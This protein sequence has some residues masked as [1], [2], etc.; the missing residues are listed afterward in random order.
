MPFSHTG[1]VPSDP[2]GLDPRES[3]LADLV[4]Q[5][6]T[7]I[8]SAIGTVSGPRAADAAE[9][10]IHQSLWQV[11]RGE[12][13]I[14]HPSSYVYKAAVR[15]TVRAVRRMG[16]S[17]ADSGPDPSDG[18]ADRHGAERVTDAETARILRESLAAL[19]ADRARAVRAHLHGFSDAAIVALYAW[20]DHKAR[21]LVMRGMADLAAAL[22]ARGVATASEDGLAPRLRALAAAMPAAGPHPDE[23][24]WVAL[25]SGLLSQPT[26][27]SVADHIA[28]CPSCAPLYRAI[29]VLSDGA[30]QGGLKPPVVRGTWLGASRTILLMAAALVAAVGVVVWVGARPGARPGAAGGA[31]APRA[32]ARALT[33]PEVELPARAASG[34][35]TDSDDGAFLEAFA[36]AIAPYRAGDFATAATRL[37]RVAR[38]FP[39]VPETAFYLGVARLLAGDA[40]GARDALAS[41]ERAE[42][43]ADAAR[44]FGA[45][46]AEHAGRPGDADAALDALCRGASAFRDAACRARGQGSFPP[47]R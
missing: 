12:Q 13:T 14:E 29:G 34:S 36:D 19:P 22:R 32:W 41:A 16:I 21:S 33:A 15:E 37:E 20:S 28:S 30:T 2:G 39:D 25:P 3:R 18:R 24:T 35:G 11:V 7:L 46:A 17:S 43:L 47:D 10:A 38:Q 45:A 26:R 40:A 5:Y 23:D 1:D 42:T 6:A 9:Q 8:R 27:R 4:R 44:W 31:P